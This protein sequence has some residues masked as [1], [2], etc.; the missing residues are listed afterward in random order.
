MCE[1]HGKPY[2]PAVNDGRLLINEV[3]HSIQGESSRAGLPCVF[4]RLRGCPL[5]CRYCDTE[6]AF[7]EGESRSIEE[8]VEEVTS[9]NCPLVEITGGEPLIQPLV[10][11]LMAQLCDRGHTVLI[12]TAGAHDISECDDRVIRILDLKTPGSGECDQIRWE[13][14]DD[15]RPVDEIKFVLTD[16]EDYDWMKHIMEEHRLVE[17]VACVLASPVFDQ[18]PGQEITGCSGLSPAQLAAWM[19]EDRLPVRMQLQLHKFIWDP[20]ARG[21]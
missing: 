9:F 16:R 14:L 20:R 10:H 2:D 19:L 12:E 6:Y 18:P 21:V 1:F 3:F 17:R 5:R 13:N 4:V 11:P 15:L 8:L 7:R